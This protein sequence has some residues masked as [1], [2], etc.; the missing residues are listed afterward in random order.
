MNL[1]S[2][3]IIKGIQPEILL[4]A[5]IVDGIFK[6]SGQELVITSALDG[7]HM[8]GSKHYI[9]QAL[10]FRNRDLD[11]NLQTIILDKMKVSLGLDFDIV[12]E[13]DHIHVEYDPKG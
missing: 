8:V 9:G 2:G 7:T 11:S 4:G 5:I 13:K 12:L 1:K 6:E 3:V 10:D